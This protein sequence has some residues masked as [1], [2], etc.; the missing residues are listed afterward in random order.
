VSAGPQRRVSLTVTLSVSLGALVVIV[1]TLVLFITCGRRWSK[2][3]LS[4]K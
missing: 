4:R 3:A 1:A 2:P